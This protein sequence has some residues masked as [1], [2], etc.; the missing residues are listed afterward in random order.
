MPKSNARLNLR[1]I[2][3]LPCGPPLHFS[4]PNNLATDESDGR[5]IFANMGGLERE[6]ISAAF[7]ICWP[8]KQSMPVR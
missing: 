1:G 6:V 4:E 2:I 5:N 8:S 3:P 7:I